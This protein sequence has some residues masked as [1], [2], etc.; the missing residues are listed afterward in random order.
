[1]S[2]LEKAFKKREGEM[3]SGVTP[4]PDLAQ[5]LDTVALRKRRN[6]HLRVGVAVSAGLG[7]IVASAA[8]AWPA[9]DTAPAIPTPSTGATQ[10]WSTDGAGGTAAP[11][12]SATAERDEPSIVAGY[13][14]VPQLP[15]EAIPW[16]KVGPG[17]FMVDFGGTV[18]WP[19]PELGRTFPAPQLDG[20]LSLV[21][22]DG[23]WYALTTLAQLGPGLPVAWDNGSLSLETAVIPQDGFNESQLTVVTLPERTELLT[24]EFVPFE[25]AAPLGNG[26]S[27]VTGYGGGG[28]HVGVVGPGPS[29]QGGCADAGLAAW[30][31]ARDFMSYRFSPGDQGRIVCFVSDESGQAGSEVV[32][33]EI[34]DAASARSVATFSNDPWRYSLLGWIDNDRFYFGREAPDE[35]SIEQVFTFD[36]RDNSTTPVDLGRYSTVLAATSSISWEAVPDLPDSYDAAY[37][38]NKV[39]SYADLVAVGGSQG[40]ND[41]VASFS[42]VAFYDRL[43][44][45]H[46]AVVY[47]EDEWDVQIFDQAG[48]PV[49]HIPVSCPVKDLKDPASFHASGGMLMVSCLD[50]GFVELYD[51]ETGERT[52]RWDTGVSGRMQVFEHPET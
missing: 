38:T 39:P 16:A 50:P 43:S 15:A 1:M 48:D 8:Y 4:A 35:R 9:V 41:Y 18:T 28:M 27:L 13:A 40:V 46:V 3:A 5:S 17:W 12:A 31:P 49:T 7:V 2:E 30:E 34:D 45:R 20:G 42:T 33:M 25:L 10:A 47:T 24:T 51:V 26:R 19:T 14:P 23:T 36:L 21:A 11:D 22:P 6:R 52:G 29:E 32:T 44:E 37:S